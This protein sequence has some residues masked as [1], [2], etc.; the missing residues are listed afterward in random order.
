MKRFTL[1]TGILILFASAVGAQ[2]T[3]APKP[4]AWQKYTV[5]G[6]GFS[7]SLPILPAMHIN[8]RWVEGAKEA[9][10]EVLLGSYAD[11]VVYT[12]Y[13][14]ENPN[15]QQSLQGF[16]SER[17][18]LGYAGEVKNGRDVSRDGVAG[19][20][21]VSEPGDGMVQF[22]IGKDRLYE[23]YALGVAPED[24]RV[25]KFFASISFAN[26]RDATVAVEGPGLPFEADSQEERPEAQLPYKAFVGK[27]V[28][29]KVRLAMKPQPSYTEEARQNAI[30]GTVVLKCIFRY[31]GSVSDIRTVSGLPYG[32][33]Q[34]AIE[35]AQRI[36]F[37]PALK[38]GKPVSM[39]I[40]L[41]YNFNLY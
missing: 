41:E 40:Q 9:R 2:T 28:T 31:N 26:T 14:L 36:K 20:T 8:H 5:N 12:V 10:Q 39:W 4:A 34:R 3:D 30:T 16:M 37:L 32:L 38:D 6:E 24:P 22:F 19:K 18:A 11:G 33:T 1:I 7:V 17:A 29:R 25:T 27:D 15:P 23:F 21:F 13:V 35:A